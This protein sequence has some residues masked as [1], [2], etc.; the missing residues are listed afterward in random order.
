M[1]QFFLSQ[2]GEENKRR[3]EGELCKV[4]EVTVRQPKALTA[5]SAMQA[6]ST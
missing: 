1:R 3:P 6:Y 2:V 5:R 4:T